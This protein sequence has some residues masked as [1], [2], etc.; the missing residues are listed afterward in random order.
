MPVIE[1]PAQAG[2]ELIELKDSN[3][4]W[5]RTGEAAKELGV[6]QKTLRVWTERGY[7]PSRLMWPANQRYY[8]L[9]DIA[10]ARKLR[11][12]AR[13]AGGG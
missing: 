9:S 10:T 2:E 5:L 6:H 8:R 11:S 1:A 13:T 12:M 4:R 3:D 7:L